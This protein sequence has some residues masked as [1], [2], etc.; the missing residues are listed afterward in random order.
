MPDIKMHTKPVVLAELERHGIIERACR[1][2]KISSET[3]RRWVRVDREFK[4]QAER[5][6]EIGRQ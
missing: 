1:S 3:F 5:A 6:L 4:A 2:A